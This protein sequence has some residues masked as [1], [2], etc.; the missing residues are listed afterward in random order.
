[1]RLSIDFSSLSADEEDTLRQRCAPQTD[2]LVLQRA[3]GVAPRLR[4]RDATPSTPPRFPTTRSKPR[5]AVS[6]PQ[7][8]ESATGLDGPSA[9]LPRFTPSIYTPPGTSGGVVWRWLAVPRNASNPL[10]HKHLAQVL[11]I[12]GCHNDAVRH[13]CPPLRFQQWLE[14]HAQSTTVE[15]D[16]SL[17]VPLTANSVAHA[18]HFPL[19]TEHRDHSLIMSGCVSTRDVSRQFDIV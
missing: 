1:M 16:P 19:Y 12:C 17:H 11:R 14:R 7:T 9:P 5:K 4:W 8:L 2:P 10:H 3:T 6:P 15:H 18:H 13:W